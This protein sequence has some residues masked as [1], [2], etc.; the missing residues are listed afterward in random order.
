MATAGS[1]SPGL[2]ASVYAG[3]GYAAGVEPLP[4]DGDR[5]RTRCARG[6]CA[7]RAVDG[8]HWWASSPAGTVGRLTW[9]KNLR[10]ETAYVAGGS[11]PFDFDDGTLHVQSITVNAAGEVVNCGGYVVPDDYEPSDWPMTPMRIRQSGS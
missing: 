4:L 8:S 3:R 1:E 5:A 11:S 9:S 6:R 7:Q 2:L 10:A